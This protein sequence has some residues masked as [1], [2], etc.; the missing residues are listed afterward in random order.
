MGGAGEFVSLFIRWAHVIAAIAWIGS[1]FYFM[2]L[3]ASL[4]RRA[5][6]QA[7]IKG[8]NWSVHGGGFYHIQKYTVAPEHMPAELHWYRWESYS[9]W[10]SGFVLLAVLYWAN[11]SLYMIDPAKAELEPAHAVV[12]SVLG[13]VAAWVAYDA[14][15]RSPLGRMPVV[16]FC[17]L[18][19]LITATAWAY[20]TIFS[21]R[22]AFLQTGAMMATAMSGNVFFVIIPNQRI[23]VADL[24]AGRTPDPEYGRIAKLRSTHNNYLTLPVVFLMLS[25]HYPATFGAPAAYVMVAIALVL[26]TVVRHWFNTYEA[27]G[28]GLRLAWQWPAAVLLAVGMTA[29][30]RLPA[31]AP[32]AA[33]T[34]AAAHPLDGAAFEIVER[35]CASCHAAAPTF[36]GLTAAPKGVV[37]DTLDAT[38]R[39]QAQIVAQSVATNAM[40]L[41]NVT[42]MTEGERA[43]LAAWAGGS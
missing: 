34:L 16:L 2:A 31:A 29:W 19:A 14:L 38:R 12:Y 21:G 8:E 30:S 35:R 4:K 24:R 20:G 15:C 3:D 9:A 39:Q 23:V 18:F 13:L 7:G 5:G 28:T 1:S 36:A 22:A 10:L 27:G 42:G 26:G 40:P 41:G 43:V 32:P 6:M 11:A 17:V 25:N 37:L 33:A